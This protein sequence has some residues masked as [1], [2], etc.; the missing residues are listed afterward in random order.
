MNLKKR[1]AI[2]IVGSRRA[3]AYGVQMAH[4]I[5]CE[6]ALSGIVVVSGLAEG[7]DTA[8][9]KGA[10]E[11]G[12]STIAVLGCGVDVYYP[13][14]NRNLQDSIADSGSTVSEL[15]PGSRP[16]AT[17]FPAR[18]RI[19]SGLSVGVLVVEGA[20]RSGT[21][22]TADHA[23]SHGRDVFAI[24]GSPAHRNSATPH[25]LLKAGAVLVESAADILEELE[26]SP[27]SQ[28]LK[29]NQTYDRNNNN[30]LSSEETAI[31]RAIETYPKGLENIIYETGLQSD[32]VS[33][34]LILLETRRLVGRTV[35]DRYIAA[36]PL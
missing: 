11:A 10:L 22:I 18:N 34:I 3:S 28:M 13:Y 27:F 36:G 12:G 15:P 6:L 31:L 1:L 21:L 24:P 2:A 32:R 23:L 9:H 20:E 35:D 17:H 4:Q 19:I 16:K 25:K 26:V 30:K 33:S 14:V 8:A 5:A 29:D 7:I